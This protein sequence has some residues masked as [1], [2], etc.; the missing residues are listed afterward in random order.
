MTALGLQQRVP[1]IKTINNTDGILFR[2]IFCCESHDL[3]L[4]KKEGQNFTRRNPLCEP[5]N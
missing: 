5:K 4:I 3:K 2:R 1:L